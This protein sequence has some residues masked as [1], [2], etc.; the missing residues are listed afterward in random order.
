M[1]ETLPS[2]ISRPILWGLALAITALIIYWIVRPTPAP[3]LATGAFSNENTPQLFK[4]HSG[5]DFSWPPKLGEP[6]PD[7]EL[8]SHTGATVRLS[9]F[10]GKVVLVEPIGMTCAACNA[11]SGARERGGYENIEPQE[12]L[13]SIEKLLPTYAHGQSLDDDRI[14][15]VQLLLY[16]MKLNAPSPKDARE[17]AEHFGFENHKLSSI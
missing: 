1:R 7:L 6:F 17:W 15:L 10:R 2:G 5:L 3:N 12:N 14:V 9:D 13:P 4:E 8:V 11:F 16:D